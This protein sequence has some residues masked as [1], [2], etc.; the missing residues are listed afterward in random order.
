MGQKHTCTCWITNLQ[1]TAVHTL[2]VRLQLLRLTK[3]AATEIA[4]G[5]RSIRIRGTAIGAMHLQV[6][7]TQ[8]ELVAELTLIRPLPV[9]LLGR[10]LHDVVLAQHRL[11][12]HLAVILAYGQAHRGIVKDG[13]MCAIV[14]WM[15]EL[16][17]AAATVWKGVGEGMREW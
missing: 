4:D 11:T 1:L 5:T 17:V 8:K 16:Q 14:E 3:F 15:F 7:E 2:Y 6:I 9:V 10:M 12:A 13:A